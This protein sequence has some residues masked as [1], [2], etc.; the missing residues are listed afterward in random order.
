M[1][2]IEICKCEKK[3]KTKIKKENETNF[4]NNPSYKIG[5]PKNKY[6]SLRPDTDI[7]KKYRAC[8]LNS[9]SS[10]HDKETWEKE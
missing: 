7:L 3:R 2:Q 10:S 4:Q 8:E 6:H 1:K 5:F 9:K